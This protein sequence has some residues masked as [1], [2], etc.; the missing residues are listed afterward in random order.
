MTKEWFSLFVYEVY[1]ES[2]MVAM[3]LGSVEI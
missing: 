1:Q 2:S 3:E